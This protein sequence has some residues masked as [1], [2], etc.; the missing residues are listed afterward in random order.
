MLE[1][2]KHQHL[3]PIFISVMTDVTITERKAPVASPTSKSDEWEMGQSVTKLSDMNMER[4]RD[5]EYMTDVYYETLVFNVATKV[6][7]TFKPHKVHYVG[8]S[9]RHGNARFWQRCR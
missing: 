9:L 5:Q 3:A 6:K 4:E 2:I 1:F 8:Q 7:I